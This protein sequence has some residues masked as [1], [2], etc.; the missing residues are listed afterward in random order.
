MCKCQIVSVIKC[1]NYLTVYGYQEF[2]DKD[3][4]THLMGLGSG[5]ML[6]LPFVEYGNL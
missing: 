5:Q 6:L 4:C 2:I 1:V 3:K